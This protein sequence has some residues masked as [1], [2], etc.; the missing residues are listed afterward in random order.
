MAGGTRWTHY[1]RTR[2]PGNNIAPLGPKV[3]PSY[4][5]ISHQ[6]STNHHQLAST[7]MIQHEPS[8][9][10]RFRGSHLGNHR[11][12]VPMMPSPNSP[13]LGVVIG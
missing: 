12:S 9:Q 6:S 1:V 13:Q 8:K 3:N 2:I 4:A 10:Q 5:M 11:R 7:M